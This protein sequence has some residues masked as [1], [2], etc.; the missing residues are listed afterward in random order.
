MLGDC[1]KRIRSEK[2][3]LEKKQIGRMNCS[4]GIADGLRSKEIE[5]IHHVIIVVAQ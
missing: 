4:E 5:D 2:K 1:N 3:G